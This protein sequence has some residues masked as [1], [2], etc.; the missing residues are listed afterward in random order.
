MSHND[1]S[2]KIL[3]KLKAFC[4]V[5]S[6]RRSSREQGLSDLGH[7]ASPWAFLQKTKGIFMSSDDISC[8][9]RA[10]KP[11]N[12]FV[13]RMGRTKPMNQSL[14]GFYWGPTA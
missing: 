12:I 10:I 7:R 14:R 11:L 6:G 4:F 5:R 9:E 3:C 2:Y 1:L 13:M 8:C